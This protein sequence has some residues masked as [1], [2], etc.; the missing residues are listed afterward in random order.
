MAVSTSSSMVPGDAS[1]K[2]LE[3]S[4]VIRENAMDDLENPCAIATLERLFFPGRTS[5]D[6]PLRYGDIHGAAIRLELERLEG[7]PG[8]EAGARGGGLHS[9]KGRR[10]GAA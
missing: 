6:I 2:K 10:E 8:P 5:R 4:Y 1:V 7:R 9:H 3:K